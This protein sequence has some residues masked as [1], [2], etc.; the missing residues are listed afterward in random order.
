MCWSEVGAI[1]MGQG[2]EVHARRLVSQSMQDGGWVLLHNCHLGLDYMD[3]L[4]ETILTTE[5]LHDGFRCWITTEVH[6]KFPINFLQT[7]IKFTAE[8]PQVSLTTPGGSNHL[9]GVELP[10]VG[11]TTPDGWT[12]PGWSNHPGWVDPPQVGRTTQCC[13]HI[14][15]MQSILVG[16]NCMFKKWLLVAS[17]QLI[18]ST[19]C[20]GWLEEDVWIDHARPARRHNDAPVETFAVRRRL[21]AH[22]CPGTKEV[23]SDRMEHSVRIQPGGL[24]IDHPV[25]TEPPGWH[26]SKKGVT[27]LRVKIDGGVGDSTPLQQWSTPSRNVPKWG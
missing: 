17:W 3:E 25:R 27:L 9:R 12:N 24:H 19:G 16:L 8:P 26:R 22:H 5:P 11:W 4:L 18:I 13:S 2:Q 10:Q 7:S 14:R 1:S 15:R 20:Q 21:P 6:P 23:R